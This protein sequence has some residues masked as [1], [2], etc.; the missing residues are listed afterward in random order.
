[1]S[2]VAPR[3]AGIKLWV[4]VALCVVFVCTVCAIL[5]LRTPTASPL[6]QRIYAALDGGTPPYTMV[7]E[8]TP[9]DGWHYSLAFDRYGSDLFLLTVEEVRGSVNPRREYWDVTTGA[10]SH[11][12][13]RS[14]PFS[15]WPVKFSPDGNW[16]SS[17]AFARSVHIVNADTGKANIVVSNLTFDLA[18]FELGESVLAFSA[19]SQRL[20][21]VTE[22][23]TLTV[24][25]SPTGKEI[26]KHRVPDARD[27]LAMIGV[28]GGPLVACLASD[29][30]LMVLDYETGDVVNQFSWGP[31]DRTF[32]FLT[33]YDPDLLI[34][35]G[36]RNGSGVVNWKTGV[37]LWALD[38]EHYPLT[39]LQGDVLVSG[40]SLGRIAFWNLRTFE[41]ALEFPAH[42]QPYGNGVPASVVFAAASPDSSWLV[43]MGADEKLKF[44]RLAD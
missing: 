26:A 31:V 39:V 41:Q 37:R 4:V 28:A 43:T 13:V 29:G 10:K 30:E 17:D 22:D 20:I 12:F 2:R 18:E 3:S 9:P 44:W 21:V 8:A 23:A 38:A 1:M 19:D 6:L 35:D 33:T 32:S 7:S 40:A 15:F 27:V 34:V 25:E 14:D 16:V 36:N 5:W 42:P 24:F 11:E